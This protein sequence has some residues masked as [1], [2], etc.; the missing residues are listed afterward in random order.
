LT[1]IDGGDAVRIQG[2][3]IAV[4]ARVRSLDIYSGHADAEGLVA[5]ASARQPVRGKVFLTHGEPD[6]LD[7]LRERL[8][9][10]G[11]PA[12]QLIVPPLDS[13]YRL[14]GGSAVEEA[15]GARLQP[16]SAARPDWHNARAKL[17]LELGARLE[18][19]PNDIEREALLAKLAVSLSDSAAIDQGQGEPSRAAAG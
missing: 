5:W 12:E 11:L 10:A 16:G 9:S 7:A 17:I 8:A 19:L 3:D 18:Q 6:A 14:T 2:E 15:A 1:L 13:R 4:R